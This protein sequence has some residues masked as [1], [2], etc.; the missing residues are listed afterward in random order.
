MK[1]RQIFI[2]GTDTEIGKTLITCIL[3]NKYKKK[4]E[5]QIYKPLLLELIK[6][7]KMKI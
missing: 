4:S 3:A 7:I 5:L 1:F 6:I 2:T